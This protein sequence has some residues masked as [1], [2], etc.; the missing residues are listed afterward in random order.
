MLTNVYCL[1][2]FCSE[3]NRYLKCQYKIFKLVLSITNSVARLVFVVWLIGVV[4]VKG[5]V[6]VVGVWL[7]SMV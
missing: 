5:V 2:K 6:K 4:G 7:E 3:E 1:S